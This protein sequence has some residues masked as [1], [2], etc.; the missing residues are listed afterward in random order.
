MGAHTFSSL[1][2]VSLIYVFL[3]IVVQAALGGLAMGTLKDQLIRF[4]E[5]HD[6]LRRLT[7][8]EE[9]R[10]QYTSATWNGE[11]RWFRSPNVVCLEKVRRLKID[12]TSNQ[13]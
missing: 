9:D 12:G 6:L 5:D 8:P 7:I 3:V 2:F 13:S 4:D 10:N 11:Y 1:I